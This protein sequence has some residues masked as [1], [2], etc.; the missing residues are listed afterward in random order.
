[1]SVFVIVL[2]ISA[3]GGA[4]YLLVSELVKQGIAMLND[5][6]EIWK[7]FEQ[8]LEG[9]SDKWNVFYKRLPVDLQT[10]LSDLYSNLSTYIGDIVNKL[11]SPAVNAVGNFVKSIPGAVISIIMCLISSYYF[12]A[13]REEIYRYFQVHMPLSIQQKWQIGFRAMKHSVGLF[14]GAVPH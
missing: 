1:M 4:L 5:L 8:D 10:T 9:L 7:N 14:C 3:V 2:A 12:V 11:G 13:E 6:P